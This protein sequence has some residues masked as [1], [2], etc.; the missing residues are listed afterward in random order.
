MGLKT[1]LEALWHSEAFPWL[2]SQTSGNL[3]V[4]FSALPFQEKGHRRL[5]LLPILL[6]G[7]HVLSSP[8]LLISPSS[9][10]LMGSSLLSLP[11]PHQ[12]Q[13]M[14]WWLLW[15]IVTVERG[16]DKTAASF[17]YIKIKIRLGPGCRNR[18]H[19]LDAKHAHISAIQFVHKIETMEGNIF[20]PCFHFY[21]K[22]RQRELYNLPHGEARRP[23]QHI[24]QRD[25]F[26]A[27]PF[28]L[29]GGRALLP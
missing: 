29:S 24:T 1:E 16:G 15:F 5:K 27:Q 25:R 8:V 26:I 23:F 20:Y 11:A 28:P 17:I 3:L 6:V 14:K 18:E 7:Q 13:E 10:M 4:H 12:A 9:V 22:A 21:F 19:S 2:V